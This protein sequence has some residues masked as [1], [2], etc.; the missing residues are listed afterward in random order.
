MA[1]GMI[2]DCYRNCGLPVIKDE[3]NELTYFSACVTVV[4]EAICLQECFTKL[5]IHGHEWSM[6]VTQDAEARYGELRE[7]CDLVKLDRENNDE[8]AE[9][10]RT[11][12]LKSNPSS[13]TRL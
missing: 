5:N 12:E 3:I 2:S 6:R 11:K 10:E 8:H 13:A 1:F 9:Y 4:H 7:F